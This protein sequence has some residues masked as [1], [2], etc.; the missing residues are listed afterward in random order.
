MA[1]QKKIFG[2][3]GDFESPERL[4]DAIRELRRNGYS[5]L[6]AYTPFAIHGIDKALGSRPSKLGYIVLLAALIGTT[7]AVLLQWWT[8]TVSYPL[9]IGG[10]PLFAWE[11]GLPVIFELSV[12]LGSFGAVLGMLALNG[13][14]RLYHPV[15]NYSKAAGLSDDRFLLVIE[16]SDQAFRAHET[17]DLM[18]AL[19]AT[20]T[21]LIEA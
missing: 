7:S 11:F 16:A 17:A 13:L 6:E 18:R 2:I 19:G 5:K 21:E 3:V 12:L 10:K 15:F 14:P 4:L 9:V 8:G 1:E 20:E